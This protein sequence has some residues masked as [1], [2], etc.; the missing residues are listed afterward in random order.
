[1]KTLLI[2]PPITD[3]TSGY[4]SLSYIESYACS[5]GFNDID[6][7]DTNIEALHYTMQPEESERI[8]KG[9]EKRRIYLENKGQ[10][11]KLEELEL[12][13]SWK[14]KNFDN[15][16]LRT[17]IDVLQ[18]EDKFY[19]YSL[20]RPA[21]EIISSWVSIITLLGFPGQ[22]NGFSVP[23]NTHFNLYSIGDL[24]NEDVINRVSN[25]FVGYY[26]NVFM[27]YLN[28]N[29]YSVLGINVTYTAQ[30]PFA[31]YISNLVKKE[32]PELKILFG[33]TAI[34]DVW[35]Y[36]ID[37]KRFFEIFNNVDACTV[38]E[39]ESAFVSILTNVKNNEPLSPTANVL[40]HPKYGHE[41]KEH[42]PIKYENIEELPTPDF[43]KL[44]WEKY[45]S[46]HPYI[47]YSPSRGC[48]WNKC[49]FCDYGLNFDSPT[50][51][52]R[53]YSLEKIVEDLRILSKNYKFIYFSVDV[54]AP[55]MLLKL[56]QRI[57][58]EGIDIR[59]GA[60]IRLEK[61]WSVERC[62]MLKQSGCTAISVGFESGN[63]RILNLIDKGTK[64][65]QV[66]ETIKHFTEAGIG[67]QM[68]GFTGFPTESLEDAMDSVNF[69][70]E[71]KHNWTF[72]GLGTFVLTK[73]A[74]VAQK[75]KDFGI[76]N[77][78]SYK[79]DDIAWQLYY[80]NT[81]GGYDED[82]E[83]LVKGKGSL[84][85]NH[86][87][88]PW[89]GGVDSPHTMFYHDVFGTQIIDEIIKP[90]NLIEM[91][92]N[93]PDLTVYLN[94]VVQKG[95]DKYPVDKLFNESSFAQFV[96]KYRDNGVGLDSKEIKGKL[97]NDLKFP[98]ESNKDTKYFLRNDGR[99]F[100]FPKKMLEFLEF[101]NNGKTLNDAMNTLDFS[102]AELL[103]L[104][105]YSVDHHFLT[106][107][108]INSEKDL[109]VS[110]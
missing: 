15:S 109:L 89:V 39:G 29:N 72:G 16:K 103:S 104:F 69:L 96:N 57:I 106:Y 99:L 48:Y 54:L 47:Y 26:N 93:K 70:Y 4:H 46:P 32:H 6:I 101:F 17:A 2:Y 59:W 108:S 63:Q 3:P 92:K 22:F 19:D 8:I 79:G 60:E 97:V 55:A 18:D 110:M 84:R 7:M 14:A 90:N 5:K 10:L 77:V 85:K 80:T 38:G 51:P 42:I 11:N 68:M 75:P 105:E 94:G 86:F 53:Q 20:Y 12:Y 100:P 33:G 36:I 88:R 52:W 98:E 1:M 87:E 71:N 45:L 43:N 23:V 44:P 74:I 95:I 91:E 82:E 65:E 56:A 78:K 27:Q 49:T 40:L 9:I 28:S 83:I 37:K 107:V 31:L 21:V 58:D 25:P 61:Y 102:N 73:G 30:L 66:K 76:S 13:Y 41:V 62:T 50:S 81:V 64:I 34:A 67:V 35:K 24:T